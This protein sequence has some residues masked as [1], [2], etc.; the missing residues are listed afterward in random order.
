MPTLDLKCWVKDGIIKFQFFEKTMATNT[1]LHAKTALSDS[2]KLSS[3]SQEI[4][5]GFL[6]TSR[7]LD[8]SVRVEI[9]E[10]FSRKM[11]NSG[12]TMGYIEKALL[13]GIT[14]YERN[15][16]NSN[17][18]KT[19]HHYKPLHFDSNYKAVGR[20]KKKIMSKE[21]SYKDKGEDQESGGS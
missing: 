13:S 11:R 3:W 16:I 9:L 5:R 12:H 19:H 1:V 21:S 2:T 20:W 8:D 15:V 7:R 18:P 6:K 14:N 4:V 10:T 17:L